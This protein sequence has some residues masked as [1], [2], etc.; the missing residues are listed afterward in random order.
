MK[1]S[2]MI[3]LLKNVQNKYG[4]LNVAVLV[5]DGFN[6][7]NKEYFGSD[8]VDVVELNKELHIHVNSPSPW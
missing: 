5:S 8:D 7:A 4:D 6:G 1:V 3:A 2:E